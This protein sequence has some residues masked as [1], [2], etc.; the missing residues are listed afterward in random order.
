MAQTDVV[1]ELGGY[2]DASR[3]TYGKTPISSLDFS[4][5]REVVFIAKPLLNFHLD[6]GTLGANRQSPYPL[7]PLVF[8]G[9][10]VMQPLPAQDRMRFE[11]YTQWY[12]GWVA[13]RALRQHAWG[14]AAKAFLA[15]RPLRSP[16]PLAWAG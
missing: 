4:A 14:V 10:S 12:A 9:S 3:C 15:T 5:T 6:A 16:R 13:R 7:P 8:A 11:G 2:Y 1:R